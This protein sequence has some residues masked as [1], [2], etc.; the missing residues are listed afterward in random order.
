MKRT[1]GAHIAHLERLVNKNEALKK[2]LPARYSYDS[3]E[4]DINETNSLDINDILAAYA[5]VGQKSKKILKELLA[6][7][8]IDEWAKECAC[9]TEELYSSIEQSMHDYDDTSSITLEE[10]DG[11]TAKCKVV[12]PDGKAFT[13]YMPVYD[14]ES[15]LDED[16][17]DENLN[18][19]NNTI[20]LSS[21]LN[22]RNGDINMNKKLE[23]R[24]AR[25]ERLVNKNESAD[26]QSIVN[27]CSDAWNALVFLQDHTTVEA[28]DEMLDL[29]G[30]VMDELGVS[31]DVVG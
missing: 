14:P 10:R 20:E 22:S 16:D 15:D 18:C 1:L 5:R 4:Y 17:M 25:L 28:V 9:S 24:I 7:G 27:A 30:E 6:S 2:Y 21:E 19:N 13:V 3:L 26:R 23:A 12:L 8:D 11:D 29:I 31:E